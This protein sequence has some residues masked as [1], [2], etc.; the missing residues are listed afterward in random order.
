MNEFQKEL[1]QNILPFWAQK[2]PDTENGG[3]YGRM[4]GN[5]CLHPQANKGAVLNCRILWT[6]SSAYRVLKHP[7]YLA[8]AQRAYDYIERY[9]IDRKYGGVFWELDYL[10]NPANTKKQTYAQGFALYGFSEFYRATGDV[11]ALEHAKTFYRL[12]ENCRDR[13]GGYLEAYTRRWQP[14]EDVRLSDKD[15]NEVK[16]MNT[17]LH[18]LEPFTNLLRIW[19]DDAL[20]ASQCHLID[21]FTEKFINKDTFHLH[22]F[23]DEKWT[24]KSHDVS[25]GHD[26]EASWLLFE[27]AEVLGD[28]AL[29]EKIKHLSL[30][31][32]EAAAEGLQPDGSMIYES[33]GTQK[34]EDRHWWV[35]A[36]TVVGMVY[37][38]RHS[39]NKIYKL[40]AQ[41][42]WKYIQNNLIDREN[43]EWY[44]SRRSTGALNCED[45]KAGFWKCPY[46]NGRMCLEM[47]NNI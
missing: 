32:A 46:H 23:F 41:K 1:T 10:G 18:I 7:E 35:Q 24:L 28:R 42:A 25:Y 30:H 21:V 36:E 38:Y 6:F 13:Q 15:R 37:A 20:I 40:R 17:H 34:D 31:I 29:S 12:I 22:L 5:N 8:I 47:I 14:I 33:E 16:T 39:G 9:F 26:I 45:D 2:M 43:G 44:W 11:R 27:A 19:R 4:D 3:F